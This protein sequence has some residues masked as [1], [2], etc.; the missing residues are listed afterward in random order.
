MYFS[1][2]TSHEEPECGFWEWDL[3][4]KSRFSC[5]EIKKFLGYEIDS[6]PDTWANWKLV[7][8][9]A[10]WWL[11]K[12]NYMRA[13]QSPD[14]KPFVQRVRLIHKTGRILEV[15]FI[16]KI[17]SIS[18][19]Q[20]KMEG[21]YLNV[22]NQAKAEKEL[23]SMRNLMERTNHAARIGGWELDL[24]TDEFY[25][26]E[27]TKTI[28]EVQD[29]FKPNKNEVLDWF[30]NNDDLINALNG[31]K[32]YV[33]ELPA[34]T[35]TGEKM[36]TRSVG[37]P[38]YLNGECIRMFV[39]IQDITELRAAREDAQ[40]HE[41]LLASFIKQLPVAIAIVDSEQKYIAA[42]DVWKAHFN[43]NDTDITG[44]S[45]YALFPGTHEIWKQYHKRGMAGEEL[46]MEE[47]SFLSS[48][49]RTEWMQWEIRPWYEPSKTAGGIIIFGALISERHAFNDAIM[50]AMVSAEETSA[51]KS[52]FLSVMS[53]EMRTP[54]NAVIGFINLLLLDPREDQLEK[55]S[56]LKFSTENL[57]VLINNI[58]DYNKLDAQKVPLEE[59]EVD[60]K[61]LVKNIIMS[62]QLEADIKK[63][64]LRLL[65]DDDVPEFVMADPTRLGQILINLISNAIKFTPSGFVSVSVTTQ[66]KTDDTTTLIFEIK[67]T[68][69]GIPEDKHGQ[70]FE[71]FT[72]AD[73][74]ITR[75]YGGT[76]LGL[77]ISKKL[78]QMM[79]SEIGL[80]SR[81]GFG[82][83]FTFT[84]V[85][86]NV[87]VKNIKR[88][89]FKDNVDPNLHGTKILIVE[90]QPINVLVLKKFLEKW[91]CVCDV[92]E[93]GKVAVEMVIK[94]DYDLVLMDLQMPV[95]DGYEAAMA[96][97]EIREEKY[98]LLPII[99]ITASSVSNKRA[100]ILQA[101]MNELIGKPFVPEDLFNIIASNLVK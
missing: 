71:M 32:P 21:T 81:P 53:H 98:R 50:K 45:H 57:L 4:D 94:N 48:D 13:R 100:S 52:D 72:Q 101:G 65:I 16:G 29:N 84:I 47:D 79:G 35:A 68:G 58:L 37:E 85:F 12:R 39:S 78:L 26:T 24:R 89:S 82:S 31:G 77:T 44:K 66:S 2:E 99:A 36:W 18:E 49:G 80:I 97:R 19:T 17:V 69:I 62:L 14:S 27:Y 54:L 42:S 34:T 6:F 75:K 9:K 10:D 46:K 1:T 20:T 23:A 83:T 43:L 30:D 3:V 55:M 70:V 8:E 63:L 38:E 11:L 28:F 33:L 15:T 7:F 88:V 41:Q 92:A 56:V 76:G 61:A 64:D 86:K 95:M 59:M 93:N 91:Q 90:D 51:I 40:L 73:S 25:W 67:D 22:T 74:N 96:I 87:A 60:L 5:D